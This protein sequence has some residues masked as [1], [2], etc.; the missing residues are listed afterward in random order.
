MFNETKMKE[1]IMP[2][3]LKKGNYRVELDKYYTKHKIAKY[4]LDS[5]FK[6][7][8]KYKIDTK[9]HIFLEPSAGEGTFLDLLPKKRRIGIDLHPHH[10]EVIKKDFFCWKPDINKNYIT[11]GNPPFGVR[12]WLALRFIN[13]AAKFS[14]LVGFILP[15]YFASDGKGSA[16]NRVK[17]LN[18]LH[19]EELPSDIFYKP[20]N[21]IIKINTVWQVWGKVKSQIQQKPKCDEYVEIYTVCTY[22]KRRC[23]LDKMDKYSCF[24]ASTFYK[25]NKIVEKFEDVNYGSGYGLIIKR[26]K[27]E[28]IK[29]LNET[30]WNLYNIRATN[31]C[32][33]IG[34]TH[35]LQRLAEG[36]FVGK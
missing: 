2:Q 3:W 10:K 18:L 12:G 31:H 9:K 23:G 11:I 32:K 21:E 22:P 30:D 19:S 16:K 1:D 8:K 15:M 36:G 7:A 4:C 5:L 17:G 24:I 26:K 13:E 27:N 34:M 33:H 35:I 14:D 20:D 25:S 29:F 6:V 28:I